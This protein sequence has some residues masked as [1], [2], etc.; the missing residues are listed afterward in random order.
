MIAPRKVKTARDFADVNQ[1]N[2]NYMNTDG[3][4]VEK[5]EDMYWSLVQI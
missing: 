5:S 1:T 2:F 3:R 4:L